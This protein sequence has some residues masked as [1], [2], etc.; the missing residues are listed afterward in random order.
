MSFFSSFLFFKVHWVYDRDRF[1][2]GC[3]LV[4]SANDSCR[5]LAQKRTR[6]PRAC[7]T[8]NAYSFFFSFFPFSTRLFFF[9]LFQFHKTLLD[10]M[11][12]KGS[13]GTG[14][15][16]CLFTQRFEAAEEEVS[17]MPMT[18][19]RDY[20]ALLEV[21]VPPLVVFSIFISFRFCLLCPEW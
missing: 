7:F 11:C 16:F 20:E 8:C 3:S 10:L 17:R 6:S 18:L 12:S 13:A 9:F 5:G 19:S 15:I 14:K 4:V 1:P 21:S 2:H